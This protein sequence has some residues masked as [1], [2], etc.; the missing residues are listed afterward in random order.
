[1]YKSVVLKDVI[2]VPPDKFS[3]DLQK[4][5]REILCEKYEG[6]LDKDLGMFLAITDVKEVGVGKLIPGDGAAYHE[7]TFEAL[8]FKP[9]MQ[10]VLDGEVIEIV[11]FG[12]FVRL[13]PLDGLIHVSQITDDF[14]S[15]DAN[16]G[17][18]I[19]KETKRVLQNGDRVRARV[20]AI[21]LD[22]EKI[23]E[24][25]IGLTMRQAGLGAIKWLEE[26]YGKV[27][28]EK[29]EVKK[30]RREKREKAEKE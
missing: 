7:A 11:E 3:K 2:R 6:I 29:E 22:E 18:L 30:P 21:S 27:T 26:E 10:E 24:S 1:M 12:A 23:R 9:E 14:I 5:V 16:R 8:M 15:Y 4:V 20:V 13:G 28:E 25:K 17:A 19:G